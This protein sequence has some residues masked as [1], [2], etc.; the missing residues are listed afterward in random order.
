MIRASQSAAWAGGRKVPD[1]EPIVRDFARRILSQVEELVPKEPS[2]ADFRR[3]LDLIFDEFCEAVGVQPMS[4]TEYS[5]ATGRADAVFNRLVIEYKRPGVLGPKL[6]RSAVGKA[7]EQ[8]QGYLQSLAARERRSL[9]RM[10]GVVFDGNYLIFV[11]AREGHLVV[12]DP[13]EVTHAS[14]ERLLHWMVAL[15]S[16]VALTPENL[17]NDFSIDQL[18]TQ[19]ILRLLKSALDNALARGDNL[20]VKLFE[21]WRLF[22]GESIDYE[23]AFGG[24]K[25]RGLKDFAR[26]AGITVRTAADAERFFFALHTYFALLVK[27]LGWLA[28]SRHLGAKLGSPV[29]GRLASADDDELRRALENL[30]D[31]GIFRHYGLVNLLE[32]DFFTWYLSAWNNEIAEALRDLLARLDDYD[33]TTLTI[34]PEETRDLFKKLYHYLLPREVR[35]NLGEYYTP[36]WLAQRILNQVDN[37]F[38]LSRPGRGSV[39]ASLRRKIRE[40]R[41]L[42]P[43]C[44]SGT[45]PILIIRRYLELG[46][47]LRIPEAELLELITKNI[48][49]F[50]LNPLAVMTARVNYL[51]AIVDLLEHRRRDVSIP[52]YLADSIATPFL[53]RDLFTAATYRLKTV[54][55]TFVVPSEVFHHSMERF[56]EIVAES[57]KA[58]LRP[59]AFLDRVRRELKLALEGESEKAVGGLYEQL[60]DLHRRGFDGLWARLIKNNFAPLT[61]GQFDYVVGNPPWVNWEHLPD[62]YREETRDLWARYRLAGTFSG[63]RPRLGAVKVDISALMTYVAL[64]AY[65]KPGGKLGFVITQSVFK[66]SGAGQGFRRFTL[67]GDKDGEVPVRVIHVDDMVDLQPFEGASNRTAVMIVEKGE[68]TQY[69]VPY[70]LWKKKRGLPRGRKLTYD[71]TSDEVEELTERYDLVAEPVSEDDPKS[72]WLTVPKEALPA[73]RKVRGRS[74]Y[75]AHAGVCTWANGVYFVEK[76][77]ERPD[78][79]VTIRN[80]TEGAKRE[81]DEVTETVEPDLLYPLLR[82]RDVQRWR[83]EPSAWILVPQDPKAPSRA[84]PEK[85]LQEDYPRTYGY[86]KRFEKVLRERSGFKKILSRR[87]NEF[88]GLMDIDTYTFAPWKVVWPGEVANILRC[89][90]VSSREELPVVP[91]QTAYFVAFSEPEEAYAV[92]ALLNSIQV[93]AYYCSRAYKH[94]SME[95]V[96]HLRV[97]IAPHLRTRLAKLAQDA[98]E[99]AARNDEH[100]VANIE[101]EIDDLGTELWGLEEKEVEAIRKGLELLA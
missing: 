69:P 1:P 7:T 15:S 59:G 49:G 5:V 6:S 38:F 97:M 71:S 93:R 27:L 25:L 91:D 63:G 77:L 13:V 64:D 34:H 94:T 2:E 22:F 92:C 19:R 65:L 16:G 78:G 30:E 72:A 50:D 70:T 47:E 43:A 60:F 21:Q 84:Y 88:Y 53:G 41:W 28:L 56:C 37:E 85:K 101:A 73:L 80:L 66:T 99:A 8:L 76:V 83:A 44:G 62:G 29:F 68:P 90:V 12:E 20:A 14:L 36:D 45:F 82:G 46:R 3:P 87:E 35:H 75:R 52:V 81:V 4:H 17:V 31:G 100:D 98:H 57:V 58:G 11:R 9:P 40:L 51:L 89:S 86:L 26:R 55:E 67:P 39:D 48:V 42:D 10:G 54:V 61:V 74:P 33:P 18:R 24:G 96:G 32:G 23:E 95:F 79:L